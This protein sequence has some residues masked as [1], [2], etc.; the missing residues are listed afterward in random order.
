MCTRLA[1]DHWDWNRMG[2]PD[3]SQHVT[4]LEVFP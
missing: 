1:I 3:E 4:A 2:V